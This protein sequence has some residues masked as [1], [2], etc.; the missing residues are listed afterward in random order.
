MACQRLMFKV[1]PSLLQE[2]YSQT[3]GRLWEDDRK[4]TGRALCV[5]GPV[6]LETMER[7]REAP[8]KPAPSLREATAVQLPCSAPFQA[9]PCPLVLKLKSLLPP[10]IAPCRMDSTLFNYTRTQTSEMFVEQ[11][12]PLRE[13]TVLPRSPFNE[14]W[15]REARQV[16]SPAVYKP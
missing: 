2:H 10:F 8:A 12:P 5:S 11:A 13:A 3:A 4:A 7:F 6:L 1:I 14:F 9:Q 15:P 16:A